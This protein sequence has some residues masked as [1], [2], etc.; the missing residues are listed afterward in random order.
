MSTRSQLITLIALLSIL[1]SS[2]AQD[3]L[4]TRH[5]VDFNAGWLFEQ[6]DWVGLNNA[7]HLDWDDSRWLPVQLPHSFNAEDTFD[8]PSGYYRGFA[9][10][11]K[12]FSVDKSYDGR[13]LK[14]HFG[15]IGNESEIWVNEHY[16]GKFFSG[17][18]PVEID[19]TDVI[20]REAENL[21]A[22]RVNN[23]H[24]DEVPPG[25]WRMDYNVYGGIYREVTLVSLAP[26]HLVK[27]DLH[28]TTPEVSEKTCL[29][30]IQ[31][32]INNGLNRLV[33]A[34]IVC[35]LMRK[36]MIVSEFGEERT[37][38][39][40]I[41]TPVKGVEARIEDVSL[42]SPDDPALYQLQVQLVADGTVI[43]ELITSIGFRQF[44]F[45]PEN[46]FYSAMEIL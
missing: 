41:I 13:I 15:A 2:Y 23:L 39:S 9:W 5:V 11:R 38:P 7:S 34:K 6:D 26:V 30:N 10:Y 1:G 17:Y 36:G 33:R 37:A 35:R 40:G 32:G 44:H 28:I 18:T 16:M 12:H 31:A 4:R 46:G 45:D 8:P 22:I 27:D 20:K 43:D 42:W 3:Q 25:R 24:N 21:I 14:L 29:L 19:I